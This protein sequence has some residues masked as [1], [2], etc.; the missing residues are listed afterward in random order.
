M[1]YAT[2]AD[3][4]KFLALQFREHPTTASLILQATTL[5]EMRLPI[6]TTPDPIVAE[7]WHQGI[8]WAI[9][10]V[11]NEFKPCHAGGTSGYWTSLGIVPSVKLGVAVFANAPA[12][13]RL[14]EDMILTQLVP[15]WKQLQAR[16]ERELRHS[17]QEAWKIYEGRY[18]LVRS[19]L[20][21]IP[22]SE[23]SDCYVTF[24][25][26]EDQLTAQF[27][28]LPILAFS[29]TLQQYEE[30]AFR[31]DESLLAYAFGG[32]FATFTVDTDGVPATVIW[33]DFTFQLD[34]AA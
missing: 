34:A 25:M 20:G 14:I 22:E 15:L 18:Q 28:L 9:G 19:A 2:V 21:V 26:A 10:R 29:C 6:A 5:R 13:P 17:R 24:S 33:R 1:L 12:Q 31:I 4:A 16:S 27:M 30:H 7:Q 8:G 32:E 23:L 11:A 3:I